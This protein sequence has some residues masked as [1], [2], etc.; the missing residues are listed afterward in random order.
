MKTEITYSA[1]HGCYLAKTRTNGTW[2]V[3]ASTTSYDDAKQKLLR[4]VRLS[5]TAPPAETVELE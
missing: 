4:T 5:L 1:R 2:H 3:E